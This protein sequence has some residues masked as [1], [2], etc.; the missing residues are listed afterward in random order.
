MTI[1]KKIDALMTDPEFLQELI[2]F[3]GK[4]ALLHTNNKSKD[5]VDQ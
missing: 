5:P 2:A 3:I 1:Q 4:Q